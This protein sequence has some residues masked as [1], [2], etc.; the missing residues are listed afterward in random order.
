M[1][2]TLTLDP[3]AETA[4]PTVTAALASRVERM[5][6]EDLPP[7]ALTVA[8]QCLLDWMGVALAGRDEPL[9]RILLDELAP[10]DDPAG[11]SI[12]GHGR[13]ARPLDAVLI[14]GAMGHALDFDDVIMPMG[15][16]TVPVAPVVFALAEERRA[17]GAEALAAFIAG[18][19]A[20]CRIA[21]LLGPSHYARG[22]HTTATTGTFGAAAAAAHLLGVEG[23]ALTHAFGLAGTQAAGLKSCFGTMS[24]PLHPGKAAQ[25]G[26]LAARLA[27]R[28]FTSDTDILASIQ[29]FAATQS[30]TAE[31][32]LGLADRGA[33]WVTEALFK[34][35]AACYLTHDSIEAANQLRTEERL[36]PDAI[37]AVSVRVPSGHLGVCN[38]QAP[39]TGLE[40]KFSLR[41][42]TALA[43]AGEDTFQDALFSDATANR[44]D[45]V[46]LRERVSIDPTQVGRGCVVSVRLKDGRTL[47]RTG[48]VSQ[49]L[50][51]LAAQQDKLERKFRHLAGKALG[52][53][54]AEDVIALCR[55][56]ERQPD[57]TALIA[58]VRDA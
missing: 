21:R 56:L 15:H 27:A 32:A 9:V 47:A 14:N 17:S 48:D 33:P 13:R 2:D 31:P 52:E 30:T 34:Y 42:T 23:E 11:V 55:D 10:T 54:R 46:A 3:A 22:W 37:E 51:D 18:V 43:L 41:M 1:T 40:C 35:H 16:P 6:L 25:N 39:A 44:P 29:G 26:L 38:I 8:K 49:P 24:K 50:R 36:T 58:L 12:L 45:L 5:R 19:E 57:L 28:G 7:A 4:A 53:A 20:E